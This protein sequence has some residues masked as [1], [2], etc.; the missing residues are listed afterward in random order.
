MPKTY[1]Q[2]IREIAIEAPDLSE[3]DLLLEKFSGREKLS[4]DFEF[5]LNL[6]AQPGL[7]VD[8][9]KLLGRPISVRLG[10][11]DDKKTRYFNGIVLQMSEGTEVP[12]SNNAEVF[13]RYWL[14]VVPE[15]RLLECKVESRIFQHETVHDILKEVLKDLDA[16]YEFEAQ[17]DPRN[18]C[19]QYRE[20]DYDFA[21]RLMEEEGIY[22]YFKHAQGKHTML[23]SD[24]KT[25]HADI[26]APTKIEFRK[27]QGMRDREHDDDRVFIWHKTQVVGSGKFTARDYSFEMPQKNLEA[28]KEIADSATVGTVKH[29]LKVAS[30]DKL[31]VYEYPGFYAKR[32]DGVDKGG[33]EKASDLSKIEKDN[34]RTTEI[35]MKQLAADDLTV[36][37]AGNVRTFSAGHKFELDNHFSAN[38]K[39]VL[40]EVTHAADMVGTYTTEESTT[41]RYKNSFH[42][43][44][45]SVPF[46]PARTT[47]RPIVHGTQTATVVGGAGKEIEPDKYGRVKVQFRWDRDQKKNLDSSCWVRVAQAWAGK[48]WGTFFLP[49]VGDEVIV[50][51]LEGDPDRP[52]IVGSVY[53]YDQMPPYN[54]PEMK[55]RSVIKTR[56]TEK[57]GTDNFNE[58][59]F[60]DKKD[61]EEIY[62][63]AE[64]DFNRVV[65]NSD[66][67]K[68][69]FD[70]KDP[71]DQ[72]IEIYNNRTETVENG[73]ETVT[74]KKGDRTVNVDTG[75]ESLTVKT[76]NRT[77]NVDTGNDS[78]TVKTGNHTIKVSAGKSV[79]EAA[80]SIELKVGSSTIK[81]T[82]TGI[83]LTSTMIKLDAQGMSQVLGGVVKVAGKSLAEISGA[84]VKI[85]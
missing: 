4:G 28:M 49:R 12:T 42:C 83:T 3:D 22:Y 75:N 52:I 23:L 30:N 54:L 18:I 26:A 20:S 7:T 56:S 39:Y 50:A 85:N 16:E 53:N 67:L 31:E 19:V 76:G 41:L 51:F 17:L 33:A 10:A 84:A 48:R 61:A 58:L 45:D 15:F 13:V 46:V 64:R 5:D 44:P 29:S 43:V 73:N 70:K 34:T 11:K 25:S 36:S 59:Y 63:H 74:I 1:T 79:I 38:G 60:E 37:G 32:F 82:P 57:G 71:G 68:V 27:F 78:L 40:T 35:R 14:K 9:A 2:K 69:G 47:A 62:L 81:I 21:R 24:K 66:T 65:E 6:L 8:F 72:T 80:Q 77:V 55:T